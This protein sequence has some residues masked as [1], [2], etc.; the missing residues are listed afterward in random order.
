MGEARKY[1]GATVVERRAGQRE[2]MLAAAQEVFGTLG[3]AQSSVQDVVATAHVSRTAFY[4]EFSDKED[5]LLVLY[6]DRLNRL[7]TALIAAVGT[8]RDPVEQVE[9]GVRALVDV[10]IVD[11]TMARVLLVEVVGAAPR[12]ERARIAARA[13]F[14]KLI[15]LELGRVPGWATSTGAERETIALAT[16]AAIEEP[17]AQLAA[18]GELGRASQVADHLVAYA[19]R[20]LT[21]PR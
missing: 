5:C 12:V 15:E 17:V 6:K 14:G 7:A 18:R 3:Y 2:R 10:F 9:V 11:P 13:R 8:T 20:A 1:A 16:M 19:L 21:P 4:R